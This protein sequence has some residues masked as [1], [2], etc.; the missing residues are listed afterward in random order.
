[1]ADRQSDLIAK[2]LQTSAVSAELL[3]LQRDSGTP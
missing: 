3:V 2:L 1:L